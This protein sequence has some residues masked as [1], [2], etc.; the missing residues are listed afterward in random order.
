[1]NELDE[2]DA[3]ERCAGDRRAGFAA[4]GAGEQRDDK[5]AP[6][7]VTGAVAELHVVRRPDALR[8]DLDVAGG[9]RE[10]IAR[11]WRRLGASYS[12]FSQASDH[13]QSDRIVRAASRR[14]CRIAIRPPS[15]AVTT[16]G[17]EVRCAIVGVVLREG[18]S[19]CMASVPLALPGAD[20]SLEI[21]NTNPSSSAI[22]GRC[23]CQA[24]GGKSVDSKAS[25]RLKGASAE[26]D[27]W[28]RRCPSRPR[29]R[30]THQRRFD[31]RYNDERCRRRKPRHK[32]AS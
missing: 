22:F 11:S 17:T 29:V 6:A 8:V 9:E 1:M 25:N 2:L 12:H 19:A 20:G 10:A 30:S 5:V 31:H 21:R 16:I 13:S 3:V 4:V 15:S 32:R 14:H 24:S 18:R 26:T 7:A 27:A 23:T 28:N